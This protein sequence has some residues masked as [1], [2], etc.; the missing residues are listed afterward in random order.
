M[1]DPDWSGF[2]RCQAHALLVCFLLVCIL[3]SHLF[4][5]YTIFKTILNRL[6]AQV[7]LNKCVIFV[8]YKDV[9]ILCLPKCERVP[10][11]LLF[12]DEIY[13]FKYGGNY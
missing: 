10:S 8:V 7:P 12:F 6:W 11:K 3:Y 1:L 4:V 9:Y 5:L 2:A 13:D